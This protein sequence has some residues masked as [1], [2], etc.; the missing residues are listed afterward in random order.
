MPLSPIYV[1]GFCPMPQPALILPKGMAQDT[2]VVVVGT[3]GA[4]AELGV[5]LEPLQD[6]DQRLM[7]AVLS[8]DQVLQ[9][10]FAQTDI[11]PLRFGTQFADGD[12]LQQY[13]Q[14]H[15]EQHLHTLATL[16]DRAEY[17]ISLTPH[18]ITL[19]PLASE[20][21][22]RDYFAAKKQRLQTQSDRQQHQHQQLNTLVATW[23]QQGLTM[24]KG[25][26]QQESE[27]L[28]VL[29][30]RDPAEGSHLLNAAQTL[31]PDW[32][33]TVSSPLPPYHFVG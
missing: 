9:K 4:I 15:Q 22:G 3:L 17:C 7:A 1:Y 2:T 31:A 11:L 23:R 30:S 20:L 19:P 29:A 6:D 26:S 14:T 24:H 27:R 13:L 16:R 32:D 10:V 28:Y 33:C 12:I 5:D 25:T 18:P 8:H 21:K